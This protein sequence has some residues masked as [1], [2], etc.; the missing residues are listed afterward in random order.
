MRSAGGKVGG[1]VEVGVPRQALSQVLFTRPS[2]GQ[3]FTLR[4]VLL[5]QCIRHNICTCICSVVVQ[6]HHQFLPLTCI[7]RIVSA[8]ADWYH[9][10]HRQAAFTSFHKSAPQWQEPGIPLIFRYTLLHDHKRTG[11]DIYARNV[12]IWKAVAAHHGRDRPFAPFT[13][14]NGCRRG[15]HV[16]Q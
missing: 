15:S 9:A 5:S 8:V 11:G 7:P 12:I 16:V 4:L 1:D 10:G 14:C 6:T 3:D 13:L 2:L